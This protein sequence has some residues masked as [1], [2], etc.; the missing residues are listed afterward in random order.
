MTSADCVSKREGSKRELCRRQV[1]CQA[2]LQWQQECLADF[3]EGD[4]FGCLFEC[5]LETFN[6][7]PQRLETESKC[8]MMHWHDKVRAG[9]VCHVDCLLGRAM[10]SDPRVVRSDRHDREIDATAF[11]QFGKTVR[12]CRVASEQNAAAISFQKI[13]VVTAISVALLSRPPMLDGKG[14]DIDPA[15]RLFERLPPVPAKLSDVAQSC[16]SK[17]VSRTRRTDYAR[18]F[19]EKMQ[20]LQIEMIEMCMRQKD[21]VDLRQLVDFE[22]RRD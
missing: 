16:P 14:N 10:R 20:R 9:G 4:A 19:I 11:A 17:Q 7:F 18:V 3:A 5:C 6:R 13:A 21:D 1:L 8:L 22:C 15:R 12:Q 2:L